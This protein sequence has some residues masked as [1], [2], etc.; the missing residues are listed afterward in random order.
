MYTYEAVLVATDGS[1]GSAAAI[2]HAC[3][4]AARNGATLHA[5]Y[6]GDPDTDATETEAVAD[7]VL[8]RVEERVSAAAAPADGDGPELVTSV[9]TGTPHEEIVAY[10]DEAGVDVILIGPTGKTPREKVQGLGS[11]SDRVAS[12]ASTSVFLVKGGSAG[13]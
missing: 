13:E 10:A 4:V 9:R 7:R 8:G 11:V 12:D 3:G 6:V 1:D 2:E 5:L